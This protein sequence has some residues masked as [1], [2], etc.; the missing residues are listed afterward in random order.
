M[1]DG[2]GD[3][4]GVF[5]VDVEHDSRLGTR[6]RE[7]RQGYHLLVPAIQ[8]GVRCI[9]GPWEWCPPRKVEGNVIHTFSKHP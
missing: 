6:G 5:A 9:F 2:A 4:F 3:G 7:C 1:R 8:V